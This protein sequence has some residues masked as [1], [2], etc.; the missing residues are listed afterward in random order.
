[1]KCLYISIK[2]SCNWC[3]M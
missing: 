3:D 2:P 1:M